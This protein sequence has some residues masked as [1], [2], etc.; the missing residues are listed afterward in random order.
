MENGYGKTVNGLLSKFKIFQALSENI[1]N[2]NT[3]G[4]KRKIPESLTFQSTLKNLILRDDTQGALKKTG[5]VFDLALEGN[6]FFKVDTGSGLATTRNG[7]FNLN[8]EGELVSIDGHKLII[9]EKTDKSINLALEN[10]IEI[11]EE[12]VIF[13]GNERFGRIALEIQDN[14]PV[15]VRQGYV[16]GSNVN[17][18]N[19]MAALTMAFRSIEASEKL[20]GMEASVDR[21]LI[22]KYGRNV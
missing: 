4:Y 5:K 16:E 1:A 2:V 21:D 3:V 7:R 8:A 6:A 10:D 9:V 18:I 15:K 11:N 12:G 20:L 14:N 13:A 22:E 19:E 17:L